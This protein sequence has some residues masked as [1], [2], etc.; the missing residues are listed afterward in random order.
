MLRARLG[1]REVDPTVS[2][3]SAVWLL[4]TAAAAESSD[5]YQAAKDFIVERGGINQRL[6]ANPPSI[7]NVDREAG[8]VDDDWWQLVR[9]EPV[10]PSSFEEFQRLHLSAATDPGDVVRLSLDA[11]LDHTGLYEW[12]PGIR[13]ALAVGPGEREG[14]APPS[15]AS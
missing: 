13:A 2:M 7:I 3:F 8:G 12:S 1:F 6:L 15:P 4:W 11:L 10:E 9:V 5:D 14:P